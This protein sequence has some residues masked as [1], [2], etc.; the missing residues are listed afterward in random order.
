[1]RLKHLS[2]Q[3]GFS[4]KGISNINNILLFFYL[5]L[6]ATED[7]VRP[8]LF[9]CESQNPR[10]ISI[11]LSSLQRLIQYNAIPQVI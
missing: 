1:M 4:L 7:V 10:L 5:V 9:A 3:Y 6:S 11:S 2:E 8:L